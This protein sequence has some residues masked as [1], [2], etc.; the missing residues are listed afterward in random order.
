MGVGFI[1][2]YKRLK[3]LTIQRQEIETKNGSVI[4]N[5]KCQELTPSPPL[6]NPWIAIELGVWYLKQR[7]NQFNDNLVYA[8]ASYN[9]GP[10]AVER[11]K[12]WGNKLPP[13]LF[14]ELIPYDETRDYVK[15]VLRSYWVYRKLY[16]Q[17]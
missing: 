15:K 1:R 5:V 4:S 11:W 3:G 16:V 9:A 7:T 12:K 14:I 2:L 13:D 17:L 10:E 8:I 6:I